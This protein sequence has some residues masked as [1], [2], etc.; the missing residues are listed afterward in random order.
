MNLRAAL[1]KAAGYGKQTAGF[2]KKF[3]SLPL[4]KEIYL[5]G[6]ER[7]PG[8]FVPDRQTAVHVRFPHG[9][10]GFLFLKVK[11]SQ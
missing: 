9:M 10:P 7:G 6:S 4:G 2:E 11:A 1:P 5:L 3:S 8:Y